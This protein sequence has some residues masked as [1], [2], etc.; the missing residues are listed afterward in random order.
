MIL[1]I[2][3]AE[4][5]DQLIKQLVYLRHSARRIIK[6]LQAA[7]TCHAELPCSAANDLAT[8]QAKLRPNTCKSSEWLPH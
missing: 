1:A 2:T 8:R 5:G 6:A 7:E 3:G 4:T